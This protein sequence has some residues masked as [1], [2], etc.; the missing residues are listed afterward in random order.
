MALPLSPPIQF[1]HPSIHPTHSSPQTTA[2]RSTG[3]QYIHSSCDPNPRVAPLSLCLSL[4]TTEQDQPTNISHLVLLYCRSI[5]MLGCGVVVVVAAVLS[6]FS[7]AAPHKG[8]AS[9]I[10]QLSWARK[11]HLRSHLVSGS[12]TTLL[13]NSCLCF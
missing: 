5:V 8:C 3:W 2:L 9:R 12:A 6:S 13:A 10:F 1:I 11:F 7:N 4:P